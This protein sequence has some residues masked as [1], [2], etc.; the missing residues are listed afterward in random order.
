M[1]QFGGHD[2]DDE[3]DTEPE[4]L[5]EQVGLSPDAHSQIHHD[6]LEDRGERRRLKRKTGG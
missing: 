5:T 6:L 2:L 4:H 1:G 3:A